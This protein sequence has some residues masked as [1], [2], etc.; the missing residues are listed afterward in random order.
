VSGSIGTISGDE[1]VDIQVAG[2][3]NVIKGVV[4]GRPSKTITG[5]YGSITLDPKALN[6]SN[7]THI[8]TVW[9]QKNSGNVISEAWSKTIS[10]TYSK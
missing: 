8:I 6:L 1:T 10:F 9:V 7:G 5:A 4:D 3:W 2:S